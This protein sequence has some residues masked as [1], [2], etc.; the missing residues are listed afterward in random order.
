MQ[1][2]TGLTAASFNSDPLAAST[3]KSVL[4]QITGLNTKSIVVTGVIDVNTTATMESMF[5]ELRSEVPGNRLGLLKT[6]L[7]TRESDTTQEKDSQQEIDTNETEER[8]G[9]MGTG[10]LEELLTWNGKAHSRGILNAKSGTFE[11]QHE[12]LSSASKVLIAY[13]LV[14][15]HTEYEYSDEHAAYNDLALKIT[16]SISSGG[17]SKEL[18][19]A[20]Q[21]VNSVAL[22]SASVPTN[23]FVSLAPAV[24]S[25]E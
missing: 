11:V 20:A 18:V 25:G 21:R 13:S 15:V 8:M 3:F 16:S 4:A 17:F 12:V 14:F 7:E 6:P 23:A 1:L 24:I 19:A 5:V 22:V 10:R 2:V 9:D